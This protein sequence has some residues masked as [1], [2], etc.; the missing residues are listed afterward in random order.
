MTIELA[1]PRHGI[2]AYDP[3]MDDDGAPSCAAVTMQR[4]AVV[5]V[6]TNKTL[7]A[8][9][10]ATDHRRSV[11]TKHGYRHHYVGATKTV[12]APLMRSDHDC[13]TRS[14]G[15]VIFRRGVVADHDLDGYPHHYVAAPKTVGAPLTC[16]GHDATGAVVAVSFF[17]VGLSPITI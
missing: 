8:R 5:A 3:S 17:G 12:G 13:N 16:S 14:S 4:C 1:K 9:R 15:G 11:C 6:D 2:V 10:S 7:C